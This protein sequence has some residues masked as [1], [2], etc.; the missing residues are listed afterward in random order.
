MSAG[1]V[2]TSTLNFTGD[3]LYMEEVYSELGGSIIVEHCKD[4]AKHASTTRHDERKY[5]SY[6]DAIEQLVGR[7]FPNCEVEANP[8]GVLKRITGS[9]TP[10]IGAFEVYVANEDGSNKQVVFSKSLTG[11]W[12]NLPVIGRYIMNVIEPDKAMEVVLDD[13]GTQIYPSGKMPT[14]PFI[15]TH[16]PHPKGPRIV[17][18]KVWGYGNMNATTHAGHK[19]VKIVLPKGPEEP[20]MTY[21]EKIWRDYNTMQRTAKP[22]GPAT[23]PADEEL[24]LYTGDDTEAFDETTM[25]GLLNTE[26]AAVLNELLNPEAAASVHEIGSAEIPAPES[27][28]SQGMFPPV[29]SAEPKDE[30]V[31]AEGDEGVAAAEEASP[32]AEAP[33]DGEETKEQPAEHEEGAAEAAPAAD[34]VPAAAEEAPAAAEETP[35]AAEEAPAAAEEAPTAAE[36]TPAAAEEAPAAAEPAAEESKAEEEAPAEEPKA[37]EEAPAPAE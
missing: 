13:D 21:K 11:K 5:Q 25:S 26:E 35:A 29:P 27:Q 32:A 4:C 23:P 30:P 24:P 17:S 19:Q 10:R 6:F 14:M 2:E 1:R 7:C 31:P 34:E 22:R 18:E 28:G 20:A 15:Y 16:S 8:P 12:P 37:E 9:K 33:A 36:E 3:A